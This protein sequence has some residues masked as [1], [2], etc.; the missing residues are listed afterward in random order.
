MD[1]SKFEPRTTTVD[2]AASRFVV[3]EAHRTW[4]IDP[5][6]DAGAGVTAGGE[7]VATADEDVGAEL[8]ADASADG[9][10]TALT[11]DEADGSA[12]LLSF[13]IPELEHAEISNDSPATHTTG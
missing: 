10:T 13:E 5:R 7:E 11:V 12:L 4:P 1:S 8:A 3:C 2:P 6:A 9:V